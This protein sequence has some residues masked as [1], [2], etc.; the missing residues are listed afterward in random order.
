MQIIFVSWV[1]TLVEHRLADF[2]ILQ[3]TLEAQDRRKGTFEPHRCGASQEDAQG[4]LFVHR[5]SD[6]I[7]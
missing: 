1:R 2:A 5:T 4:G 7:M 3:L 6:V